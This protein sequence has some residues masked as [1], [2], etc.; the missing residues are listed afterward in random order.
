MGALTEL[1]SLATGLATGLANG[2]LNLVNLGGSGIFSPPLTSSTL[3]LFSFSS[4]IGDPLLAFFSSTFFDAALK[5]PLV[6]AE[7]NGLVNMVLGTCAALESDFDMTTNLCVLRLNFFERKS[8][9]LAKLTND[10]SGSS[11]DEWVS[12]HLSK[13]C[14]KPWL[15][16]S[17][18][19]LRLSRSVCSALSSPSLSLF[20]K[21]NQ[22]MNSSRVA[23]LSRSTIGSSLSSICATISF[24]L[25]SYSPNLELVMN[26]LQQYFFELC[27]LRLAEQGKKNPHLSHW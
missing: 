9:G 4:K 5:F 11:G 23:S 13:S 12:F 7:K 6:V 27:S 3:T 17:I 16:S 25:F 24:T 14:L 2:A 18:W 8:S 21:P 26:N 10:W 1:G 19:L 20:T 22:D 15:T